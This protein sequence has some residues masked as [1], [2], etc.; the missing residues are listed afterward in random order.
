MSST[1]NKRAPTTATQRLKQ[2][3]LRI[4]KDP[5]PYICAEPLPSNILE[6]HYVVR[7]P[8]MTPYE[9]GYYHGKLIFPREFPFK[10]PSI[11]MITPNGR[12]KCNTRLCLSITDFHPDT[13]NPAWSVSTILTGLLSFMVEKGPTLG[14]IETSDFTEIKQKQKAQDELSSRPQT[15][16]LPDVVPDGETHLVQNGIQLLNGHAPGAVP[17]LAGLQQANRHHGLLGGAL[18][19]LFVIVGFAAFAYTVK[20]VLRSIAQE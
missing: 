13:W 11:Y 12:F 17:N 16:P 1:S 14:S 2:D 8:E 10:P 9:G 6:W 15:L 20:Y 3:Y 7:G 18:A 4:K 5:V 19:N